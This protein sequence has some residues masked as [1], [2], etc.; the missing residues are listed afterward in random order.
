MKLKKGRREG[1]FTLIELI[2]VIVILG[3][4]AA[5][6]VPRFLNLS[7]EA[8]RGVARG[9]TSALRGSITVLHSRL[10]LDST[11]AYD[12]TSVVNGVDT[13][14]FTLAVAG[15]NTITATFD[16]SGPYTWTYTDDTGPE[17]PARVTEAF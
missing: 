11:Q 16:N 8:E 15:A 9:V 10:L 17:T 13:I 12:A 6:A 5:V 2:I 1:G 14:G 7:A 3:I 4:L